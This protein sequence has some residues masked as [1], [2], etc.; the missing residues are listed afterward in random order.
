MALGGRWIGRDKDHDR[1]SY[2]SYHMPTFIPAKTTLALPLAHKH[3]RHACIASH[4]LNF[5]KHQNLDEWC[6]WTRRWVG[7]G[8]LRELNCTEYTFGSRF[9]L[10]TQTEV[11][12]G[13]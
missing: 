3:T 1:L 11:W 5:L 8:G 10:L 7:V 4:Q 6:V 9:S 2:L 13:M 12:E